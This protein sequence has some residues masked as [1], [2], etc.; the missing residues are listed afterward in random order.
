MK[1]LIKNGRVIDPKNNF[2]EIADVF[3]ENGKI[4]KIEKKILEKNAD[5]I[6]DAKN[7]LVTPG[8]VDLHVHFRE[9]G[10]EDKETIETGAR[11]ALAGGVT[12]V[13]TMPNTNPVADNQ[14][15]IE[16]ILRRAKKLNLINIFPVGAITKN[17]DGK[18]L[19]EIVET[20]NS[21]A[22]A[23]SDDGRD[24]QNENLLLLAMKYA[25]TFDVPVF[26]HCEV[27]N[28]TKNGIMHE[29]FF[30][31]KLG[32]PGI[33]EIGEILGIE[34]NILCAQKTGAQLHVQ[35]VS[36]AGGTEKIRAAK[37][38]LKNLSAETCPHYFSLTDAELENFSTNAKINPPLRDEKN[39]K[40]LIAA[41]CDGTIDCF[42]TDHA[43][44]TEPE[45]LQPLADAPFGSTGLETFF[46]AANTFL[47][48]KNFLKISDAIK[49]MTEN[50]A[51]ILRLEKKGNLSRGADADVAI[52][53]AEKKWTVDP[54]NFF[55][56]GKNSVF[57][58]K[59]LIGKCVATFV[60]GRK[61]F[62][63]NKIIA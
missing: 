35:H 3:L 25:R 63:E 1:I 28:L 42:S 51:K 23:I 36:T 52:F 48:K 47:V 39:L 13:A 45:K 10:R 44:H 22:I 38:I 54:K 7:F 37:K 46:A 62:A 53:D 60:G 41:I 59:K 2:D 21:G 18:I 50:P 24:V 55:S 57:A 14:S 4:A 12:S 9:P 40:K 32:L 43:P 16:F 20:K 31:T 61:K 58:G 26:S 29:G 8:L 6:F 5:E 49:K 27:E 17:S 19:S 30:S 15:V 34:K 11:A 33:P 56:K